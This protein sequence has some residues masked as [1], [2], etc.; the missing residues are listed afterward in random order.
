MKPLTGVRIVSVEQFG[1]APY[2][3]MFLADLGAEVIKVENVATGGDP[4]RK[5]GPYLLGPNDSE[6][7][8]TWNMNKKSVALD[9]RTEEGKAAL[10]RLAMGAEVVLNNLRGD[11]PAKMGLDYKTLGRAK[12]SLVCVHVSAYGRDNERAAWPGYDY[13]MQ[14]ETGLMHLTGE[15]DSPPTRIGAPSMVDHTT[16]LTAMVGLLSALIQARATGKGCDVDTCLFDAALHQLGYTAIWYLNEGHV[17]ERQTRSAHFS[18]APVQ[19]LPTADGWVFVMCL[20]AK[21]WNALLDILGR[22]DLKADAR[23]ATPEAPEA[24]HLNRTPLTAALD[25][26]FRKHPT[27]HWMKVLAGV[28]PIAPVLE[29]DEA[30][31]NPF[32][33]TTGMIA[34]VPHPERPNMRVLANPIKI[35]GQRLSQQVCSTPGADNAA[36][37]AEQAA[38]AD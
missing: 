5:T 31:E 18:L 22:Q 21:F 3:S 6:Y 33:R 12:P 36:V 28:L 32:L 27:S 2:G 8:Q 30:L 4:A 24:R 35:N 14:A 20:T 1:A 11:L 17:P 13:L 15:P 19:T 37:L 25:A 38:A 16:G 10:T 26:E 29:L 9:L 7:F 34:H 23:F